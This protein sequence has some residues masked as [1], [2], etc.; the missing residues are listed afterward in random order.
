MKLSK[1]NVE[2]LTVTESPKNVSEFVYNFLAEQLDRLISLLEGDSSLKI[3]VEKFILDLVAR[4]ALSAR[5]IFA[6]IAQTSLMKLSDDQL[7]SLVYSKAEEDFIWIRL[8]GSIIGS[9]IG[10]M[11]F[12]IIQCI[13][14]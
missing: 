2:R 13:S 1:A 9:F 8:N 3:Q 10:L 11:V 4:S 7:N 12:I 6:N 14:M 5:P